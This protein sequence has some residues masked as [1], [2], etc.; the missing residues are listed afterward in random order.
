MDESDPNYP[1]V[2]AVVKC[3]DCGSRN[4]LRDTTKGETSCEDC[5][6]VLVENEIDQGAEWR[7]FGPEDQGKSRTG[8]PMTMRIHDKG[9][10]TDID[11][12]NRDYSGKAIANKTRS[13]IY[14]MRKWQTRA[15]TS[16][17]KERNLARA[18]PEIS[19]ICNKMGLGNAHV[20][21]AAMIYRRAVEAEMIRGRSIDALVAASVY[22]VCCQNK[23]GRTLEEVCK[24]SGLGRKEL[25]RTYKL[26]KQRL[27]IRMDINRPED[28]VQSFC[29]K[30]GLPPVVVS[31]VYE[32][33]K[34][35]T[36]KELVDGK[37]PTGVAA[38][39]IYIACQLERHIR[40]QLEISNVSNVT[41]VTIRNRY[42]E[43]TKALGIE[44]EP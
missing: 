2:E 40:T 19:R 28:Y 43:L 24:H 14:R 35:A 18:L 20:E 36:E 30:L 15:R 10:S 21:E 11:W 27:R 13:Q 37:S 33:L 32:L 44:L 7:V 22:A 23:L 16:G 25:T 31:R 6:L 38:A 1:E 26:L 17:S 41:E 8:A 42:K 3:S 12:Q 29:S 5:G 34:E 9:L 39:S 4:L